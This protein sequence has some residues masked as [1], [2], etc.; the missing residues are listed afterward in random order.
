M[1]LVSS[2]QQPCGLRVRAPCPRHVKQR[3]VRIRLTA[4]FGAIEIEITDNLIAVR[5]NESAHR[6]VQIVDLVF[7]LVNLGLD[8]RGRVRASSIPRQARRR[9]SPGL[10]PRVGCEAGFRDCPIDRLEPLQS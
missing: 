10:L 3:R 1:V 2:V 5:A 6:L 8:Y 9:I 7:G 4:P